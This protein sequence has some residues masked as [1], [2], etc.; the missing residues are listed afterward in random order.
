MND[1]NVRGK[2]R[3]G[4]RW[5]ENVFLKLD[6]ARKSF[7]QIYDDVMVEL[8]ERA[9]ELCGTF[10]QLLARAISFSIAEK[11]KSRIIGFFKVI[12]S[13]LMGIV[14][15]AIISVTL[16]VATL[17]G[18]SVAS[19]VGLRNLGDYSFKAQFWAWL[20]L[21]LAAAIAPYFLKEYQLYKVTLAA[22]FIVGVIGLD[23]LYGHCG[24]ISLGHGGFLM[25]SG[26]FTTWICNGVFAPQCPQ[27]LAVT[28]GALLNGVF[29]VILGLPALRA[30]DYYLV[31]ATMTFSLAVPKI[32][33]SQHMASLS[34]MKEGGLFIREL[35][36][37]TFLPAIKP[38]V[39]QY[40]SIIG[41]SM[42]L[43][44][45]AY[46]IATR[47]Q[48][49]RAFRTIKCDTEASMIVGIPIVRY[50]LLAFTLS[51]VY[52]GFSGGFLVILSR[53]I[54]PDSFSLN[55]SIDF[56]V[57]NVVGGPGSILGSVF[58]GIFLAFEQDLTQYVAKFVP[59]GKDLARMSYG[60]ILIFII[61]FAP[62]GIAGELGAWMKTKFQGRLRRGAFS[63]SPPPDY[64]VIEE[65]KNR[66]RFS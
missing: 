28:I 58:G 50:K 61:L 53:Y 49:G 29:G 55:S 9:S 7:L 19:I 5:W 63:I 6:K 8:N 46:F 65:K 37:P 27:L 10:L 51:G 11:P 14:I 60:F 40:F 38:Y 62:R 18:G 41:P 12:V 47:S 3:R 30:K 59:N 13:P 22:A 56:M 35:T 16:L 34:G 36:P 52:A 15:A 33:K 20:V 4:F 39:W 1:S 25:T 45:F 43:I 17:I 32:L 57:A 44:V 66:F 2:S 54:S 64:D 26:Y 48:I 24:I 31:I 21:L 42:L 23:L